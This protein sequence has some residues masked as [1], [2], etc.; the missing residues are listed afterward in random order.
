MLEADLANQVRENF[1]KLGVYYH[2]IE[3]A[4]GSGTPDVLS[5]VDGQAFMLELKVLQTYNGVD[6]VRLRLSQKQWSEQAQ[7]YAFP[8]FVLFASPSRIGV[9][10]PPFAPIQYKSGYAIIPVDGFITERKPYAWKQVVEWIQTQL[11]TLRQTAKL[12]ALE[13]Y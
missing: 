13:T 9:M 5:C 6:V 11:L 3:N 8:H 10:H 1:K 4:C 12:N 7:R 2:R